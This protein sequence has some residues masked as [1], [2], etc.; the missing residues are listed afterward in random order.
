[1]RH[2]FALADGTGRTYQPTQMAAHA[3]GAY[4]TR[5]TGGVIKDD[6]LMPAIVA[7]YLASTTAHTQLLVKLGVNDGIAIKRV[8]VHKQRQRFAHQRCQLLQSALGQI[9]A[10]AQHQV[11]DN[12]IA[13]LHYGGAHLHVAA[14]QLDELQSITPCFNAAN[15]APFELTID[16]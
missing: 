13:I 8:G 15:A 6:G 14:A 9:A 5:A 3:A 1:M 10:Q 4:Q 7:R 11:V 2:A 12:A 16:N